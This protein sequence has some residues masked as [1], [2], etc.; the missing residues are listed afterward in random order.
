MGTSI[1]S[2][3]LA[4]SLSALGIKAPA[5]LMVH[6]DIRACLRVEGASPADKLR[7]IV[8]ALHE[9]VGDGVLMMPTFTYSACNGQVF[10]VQSSPSTV[11][12]LTEYFRGLP[13]VRRTGDPIFSVAVRGELPLEWDQRLFSVAD[14]DCFG[15]YSA[16]SYLREVDAAFLF[17]GV[18]MEACTFIHH[19]EQRHQVPYRY[20][21][22]FHGMV[23]NRGTR[24]EV[25][26]SYFVRPL[27]GDVEVFLTPLE[28]ALLASGRARGGPGGGGR[29]RPP[30]SASAIEE[31]AVQH[32]RRNPSFLLRRG[33]PVAGAQFA[34]R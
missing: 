9:V 15:P 33:H 23:E 20:M 32:L 21:K 30:T 22:D 7:T 16:F 19:V 27:D 14:V 24:S 28:E 29:G 26:A 31:E 4:A 3:D 34:R 2:A 11:G 17:F 6:S 25:T 10:D 12:A 13:G 5:A 8:R 1:S 18:G